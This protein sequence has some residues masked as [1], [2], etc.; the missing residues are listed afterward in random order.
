MAISEIRSAAKV[1]FSWSSSL[2][3]LYSPRT[4]RLRV[5]GFPSVWQRKVLTP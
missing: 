2:L 3:R 4:S 5:V 1:C